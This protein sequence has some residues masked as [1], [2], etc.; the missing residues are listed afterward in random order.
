MARLRP[1]THVLQ[2][3]D[4]IQR[5]LLVC[6][7]LRPVLAKSSYTEL[8]GGYCLRSHVLP[9]CL[10]AATGLF[11]AASWRTEKR[12]WVHVRVG[13][14]RVDDNLR[15]V[16]TAV[17]PAHLLRDLER[18]QV[19]REAAADNQGNPQHVHERG[20]AR[21]RTGHPG[22]RGEYHP[23]PLHMRTRRSVRMKMLKQIESCV[24]GGTYVAE[25]VFCFYHNHVI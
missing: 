7:P 15:G 14:E 9:V 16:E 2:S 24:D 20:C 17:R 5:F 25:G 6:Q 21:V 18:S 4:F 12:Y 3:P 1:H 19:Q 13:G 11:H 22:R 8:Y 10:P 23:C